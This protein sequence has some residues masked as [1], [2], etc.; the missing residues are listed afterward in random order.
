MLQINDK[1]KY[2]KESSMICVPLGTTFV[3]TDVQGLAIALETEMEY[4]GMKG[5][6][7]CVMSYDEYEKYFE[8]VIEKEQ[9]KNVW[10]EWRGI[11]KT[12][13]QEILAGLKDNYFIVRYLKD[14]LKGYLI[15]ERNGYKYNYIETRNNGKKTDVRIK[16]WGN[17]GSMK[18]TS[19]CNITA[20][21]KFDETKGIE[22][23]LIK[24][25]TKQIAKLSTNYI[26]NNY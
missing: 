7:K 17:N 13:L 24:L 12:E 23:A 3:V 10:T 2:V 11:D 14:Y 22:I 5:I 18:A 15:V 1:I 21:D 19:T 20:N 4:M 6:A 26:E 16:F 25:F 9:P 8:K